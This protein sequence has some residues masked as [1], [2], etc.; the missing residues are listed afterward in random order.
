MGDVSRRADVFKRI[1]TSQSPSPF[2]MRL[3]LAVATAL[4]S[5]F[6]QGHFDGQVTSVLA[7]NPTYPN[8]G[9]ITASSTSSVDMLF[10]PY[11]ISQ[12]A[13]DE[14]H[15]Q[16]VM[17]FSAVAQNPPGGLGLNNNP[18]YGCMVVGPQVEGFNAGYYFMITNNQ[19][20]AF[21]QYDTSFWAVPVYKRLVDE[22]NTYTISI[23][24]SDWRIMFRVDGKNVVEIPGYC[25]ID[26]KF[27]VIGS[28]ASCSPPTLN[29]TEAKSLVYVGVS[30][31]P[32]DSGF[33]QVGQY[34]MCQDNVSNAL[35]T[36]CQKELVTLDQ[37]IDYTAHLYSSEIFVLSRTNRCDG[38]SSSST[39][40]LNW[41]QRP[42]KMDE[43]AIEEAA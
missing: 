12:D 27:Q 2:S 21:I 43:E 17:D 36:R 18:E 24:P 10:G 38:E 6:A 9:L 8:D 33:C 13:D 19:V 3:L 29:F 16:Y 31:G 14:T 30:T 1:P 25:G 34:N 37:T 26:P 28:Y 15:F 7:W 20:Y 4:I 23:Q 40:P 41:W 32:V 22:V 5:I 39:Q 42:I 35:H 11:P